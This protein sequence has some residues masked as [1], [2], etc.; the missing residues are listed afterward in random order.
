MMTEF[1]GEYYKRHSSNGISVNPTTPS[2][3]N[4][5]YNGTGLLL[6]SGYLITKKNELALRYGFV[7]PDKSIS[8]YTSKVNE[9]MVAYSHYFFRHNLKL[10]TDA[11]YFKG[12]AQ[13][14]YQ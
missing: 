12:P 2:K 5:V 6:Q 7:S 10:Q 13:K 11:G 4:F 1:T 8:A 9:Y 14:V 3:V